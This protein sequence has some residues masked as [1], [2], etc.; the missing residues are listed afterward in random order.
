MIPVAQGVRDNRHWKFKRRVASTFLRLV[1]AI[2]IENAYCLRV[3]LS[4][5]HA[6]STSAPPL[7]DRPFKIIRLD[8][9]DQIIYVPN[10]K[11]GV[12]RAFRTHRRSGVNLRRAMAGTCCSAA[13]PPT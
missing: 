7:V 8:R 4:L 2:E 10:A 11:R 12:R 1:S 6:Q 3:F 9:L 5:A 13:A